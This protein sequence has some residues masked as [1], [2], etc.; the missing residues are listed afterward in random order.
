MSVPISPGETWTAMTEPARARARAL[1][2]ISHQS[3]RILAG[4]WNADG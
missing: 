3:N 2:I 1:A 4:L